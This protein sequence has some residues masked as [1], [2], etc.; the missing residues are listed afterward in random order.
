MFN[1]NFQI[2]FIP[3]VVLIVFLVKDW[4]RLKFS[5]V[6]IMFKYNLLALIGVLGFEMLIFLISYFTGMHSVYLLRLFVLCFF[7]SVALF[8]MFWGFF[9]FS[10]IKRI[11]A[12]QNYKKQSWIVT[13]STCAIILMFLINVYLGFIY[14]IDDAGHYQQGVGYNIFFLIFALYSYSFSIYGLIYS[15]KLIK[16]SYQKKGLHFFF[17]L[18]VI[19]NTI[20][21]IQFMYHN[22]FSPWVLNCLFMLILFFFL[23][24]ENVIM[25][26]LTGIGNRKNFEELMAT[27]F[28]EKDL[29]S[30]WYLVLI[31]IDNF[32]DV[33]TKHG[34]DIGDKVIIRTSHA[35]LKY[36]TLESSSVF[37]FGGDEFAII[38]NENDIT[39]LNSNLYELRKELSKLINYSNN[40][41]IKIEISSSV[42]DYQFG[43]YSSPKAM[44]HKAIELL[45]V[46][47]R[48]K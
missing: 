46:E 17:Y 42:V 4:N 23:Q 21:N 6:I 7:I 40:E 38:Y 41:N 30:V 33:N 31:D 3:A 44:V 12:R 34:H 19:M 47:K 43:R 26:V 9:I 37:R 27:K 32:K 45:L 22:Q 10:Y 8:Y 14:Y 28:A 20:N 36:F 2:D 5:P 39:L 18:S 15:R 16:G 35:L 29:K 1:Y 25:D 11:E 48:S 24:R 13:L